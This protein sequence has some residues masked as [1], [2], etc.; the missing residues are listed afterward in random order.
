MGLLRAGDLLYLTDDRGEGS[1]RLTVAIKQE[2]LALRAPGVRVVR[3]PKRYE[4]HG[5]AMLEE[6]AENS[7]VGIGQLFLGVADEATLSRSGVVAN[8][9][10]EATL[11]TGG[12]VHVEF[13]DMDG[14]TQG[15]D[16]R[17]RLIHRLEARRDVEVGLRANG[18]DGHP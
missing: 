16:F 10:A 9:R 13:R 11:T 18:V 1:L 5:V 12:T 3:A 15:G 2:R 7:R 8:V 6:R 17:E 4:L 14:Q